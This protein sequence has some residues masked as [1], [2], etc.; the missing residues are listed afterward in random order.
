MLKNIA[1]YSGWQAAGQ[2][3]S[4][5]SLVLLSLLLSTGAF[6]TYGLAVT[7]GSMLAAV[8]TLRLEQTILVAAEDGEAHRLA[9]ATVALALAIT[10][11]LAA[12]AV[13]VLG[14]LDA[15]DYGVVA[16]AGVA[17]ALSNGL[18]VVTQQLLIR[19][20]RSA[21]AGRMGA[22]RSAAVASL[23]VC[24]AW[25]GDRADPRPALLASLAGSI[26]LAGYCVLGIR[27][28]SGRWPGLAAV[29]TAARGQAD[30][31][32]PYFGQ[33]TISGLALNLPYYF[34]YLSVSPALCAGFLLAERVVRLPINLVSSSIRSHLV[35]ELGRRVRSGDSASCLALVRVWSR[36]LFGAGVLFSLAAG[37][38]LYAVASTVVPNPTWRVAAAC[39]AVLSLWSGAILSSS[40]S[41]ALLTVHRQNAFMMKAQAAELA[42]KALLLT[43]VVFTGDARFYL[44]L[45]ASHAP[46]LVLRIST[47]RKAMAT[48]CR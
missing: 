46:N 14:A 34:F 31:W 8:T 3:F 24:A 18:L 27:R 5:A 9:W 45:F 10:L 43:P 26:L 40:P 19:Q 28:R 6:A 37:A 4:A 7:T 13:P 22:T 44:I 2:A 30:V 32:V 48:G 33:S 23:V 16:L 15:P 41:A 47:Y 21:E 11:A 17:L 1:S 35:H 36:T 39:M 29:R 42:A 25:L 12:V 20:G 38:V